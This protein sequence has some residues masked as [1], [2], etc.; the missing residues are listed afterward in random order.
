[1]T[2]IK[3]AE[4]DQQRAVAK[5]P[6]VRLWMKRRLKKAIRRDDRLSAAQKREALE[7]ANE[8]DYVFYMEQFAQQHALETG[9]P[10]VQARQEGE[11]REWPLLRW[12]WENRAAVAEFWAAVIM[13]WVELIF[14]II[15]AILDGL[16]AQE[17]SDEDNP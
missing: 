13:W 11:G 3:T 8:L 5:F 2:V 1:M 17:G 4:M 10:A 7:Y 14:T 9:L 15:G 16:T 6:V 12:L